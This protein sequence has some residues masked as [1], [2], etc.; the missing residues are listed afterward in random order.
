MVAAVAA[1]LQVFQIHLAV[2]EEKREATV[3]P[4]RQAIAEHRMEILFGFIHNEQSVQNH[5][6]PMMDILPVPN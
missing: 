1:A 2:V 6:A 3:Q 5:Y 4:V